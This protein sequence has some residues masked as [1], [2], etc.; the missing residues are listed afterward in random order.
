MAAHSLS[1]LPAFVS[2]FNPNQTTKPE[3]CSLPLTTSLKPTSL[4]TLWLGTN[5][6][7]V[8]AQL[9][10]LRPFSST[11]CLS[12]PTAVKERVSSNEEVP[13]WSSRAIKSFA[14]GE[15]EARRLKYPT[16]GTEAI[17]MGILIEGTT[18]ASKILRANGVTLFKVREETIKLLGKADMYFFSPEHPALTDEAQ[19][20]LDW[21]VDKKIKSGGSGEIT[22][23]HLLLGIWYE[24]DSPGH[25]IMATLGFNEEKVKELESLISEPGFIDG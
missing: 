23:S 12:L 24:V 6:L 14:M 9:P 11:I 19:R 7:G 17:L 5:S 10:K 21:A 3:S 18:L 8:R 25:K 22:T 2:A 15:L 13:K 4:Q 1:K 16:T 20:V